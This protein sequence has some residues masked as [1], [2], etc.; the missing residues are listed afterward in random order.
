MLTVDVLGAVEV[1]RDGE[2]LPVPTGKTTEVLV[3]L[4]LDAGRPV[5]SERLI[6][7]L[8]SD[9]GGAGRNT[10]Q[11]KVS[12]LR[13]ALGE[14]DLVTAGS[15]T[16]TLDVEPDQVDALVVL[17]AAERVAAAGRAGADATAEAEATAALSLFRGDVLADAGDGDW[18]Q[19]HRTRL[20]EVRLGLVE[21]RLAARVELGAGAT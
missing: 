3:R 14:P 12:Q 16:Y 8:W 6:E 11:S 7:D 18:L 19:P 15:G 13:R 9:A 1:R 5:R 10:L 20:E 4:A 2:V 21:D 17:R